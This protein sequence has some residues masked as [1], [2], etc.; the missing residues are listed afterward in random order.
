MIKKCVLFSVTLARLL[1]EYGTK[2]AIE[3]ARMWHTDCLSFADN[4]KGF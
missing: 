3:V 4:N 2:V 1:T